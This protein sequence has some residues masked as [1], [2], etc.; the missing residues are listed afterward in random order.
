MRSPVDASANGLSRRG[1]RTFSANRSYELQWFRTTIRLGPAAV[2]V[3]GRARPEDGDRTAWVAR[4]SAASIWHQRSV[5][6][7][8]VARGIEVLAERRTESRFGKG[9]PEMPFA[10]NLIYLATLLA[11]RPRLALPHGSRRASTATG[12]GRS[13]GARHRCGSANGPASGSTPSALVR[14][15]L[16]RPLVQ[17]MARRRPNWEVVIST[18]TPT[19]LAVA[20]RTFPDLITF[21]AP[22]DFSW[23]TGARSRGSGRPCWPWSSSSSGR[24]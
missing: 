21:Y 7:T 24:T 4:D 10:L 8:S 3:A 9:F 19:G 11:L 14:C 1:S 13:S 16:L 2:S 17:E 15:C 20:R 12:C 6:G 22:L 18:T 5:R 23:A